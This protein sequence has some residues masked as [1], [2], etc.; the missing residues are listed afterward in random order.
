MDFS[1]LR[2]FCSAWFN[3]QTC[4]FMNSRK[5]SDKVILIVFMLYQKH[6]MTFGSSPTNLYFFPTDGIPDYDP[7]IATIKND[8]RVHGTHLVQARNL[9]WGLLSSFERLNWYNYQNCTI[10]PVLIVR[11]FLHIHR[12]SLKN[13]L[14]PELK[15][16][17]EKLKEECYAMLNETVSSPDV[18]LESFVSIIDSPNVG[19]M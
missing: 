16:S 15:K 18:S 17:I 10:Y 4:P 19:P 9:G 1:N 6:Y 7:F 3:Y 14:I 2:Y 5:K 8:V 12:M 11:S 13:E